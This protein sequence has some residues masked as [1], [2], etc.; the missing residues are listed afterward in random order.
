[1]IDGASLANAA[2]LGT[3]EG[4]TEFL[5]V[6]GAAHLAVAGAFLGLTGER[7]RTFEC[8]IQFGAAVA[9]IV[10]CIRHFGL[11]RVRGLPRTDR[12]RLA[13]IFAV[14]LLPT[15]LVALFAD[16]ALQGYFLSGPS[17]VVL[18][19]LGGAVMLLAEARSK[20]SARVQTLDG[21]GSVD[22]FKIGLL[23]CAGFAALGLGRSEAT[24]I[25]GLMLGLS[26]PAATEFSVLLSIPTLL[27][28]SATGLSQGTQLLA[29]IE[30]LPVFI[31]AGCAFLSAWASVEWLLRWVVAGSYV[32]FAWYRFSVGFVLVATLISGI[33]KWTDY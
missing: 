29:A 27:V 21:L 3:I 18:L 7:L 30:L 15:L 1:M 23:Q 17:M 10:T 6:S 5:P 4:L 28:S 19:F 25:G 33:V 31:G 22:A 32:P 11:A 14:A 16:R 24:I 13:M 9:M 12:A 26:R 20:A 2:L 8:A